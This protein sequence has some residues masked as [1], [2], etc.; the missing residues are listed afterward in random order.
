MTNTFKLL[1]NDIPRRAALTTTTSENADYPHE[2]VFYGSKTLHYETAAA[3]TSSSITLD[4]GSGNTAS[5][6]Y[7]ALSG[8]NGMIAQTPGTLTIQLR[9]STDNFAASNVLILEKAAIVSGDLIGTYNEELMIEQEA[10]STAYRYWRILTTSS[11]SIIH[12]YRKIYFGDYYDFGGRSPKYPYKSNP[13]TNITN[14]GFMSDAG[15]NFVTSS[16]RAV[17]N[18]SLTWH[19]LPD[20][21]KEIYFSKI[22]NYTADYPLFLYEPLTFDHKVLRNRIMFGWAATES[23]SHNRWKN[24]NEISMRFV[25]DILG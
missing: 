13:E 16:G 17:N 15:T 5:A 10:P 4:M 23:A 2:N 9:A 14:K 1:Y 22:G 25:E 21:E 19:A 11:N 20:S 12:K 6:R 7:I 18:V 3:V 8:V 24:A